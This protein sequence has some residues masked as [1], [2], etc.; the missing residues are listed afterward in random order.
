MV[1]SVVASSSRIVFPKVEIVSWL[2]D[3]DI[4]RILVLIM[5]LERER[6]F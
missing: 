5:I 3:S 4:D 2:L 6:V 1:K